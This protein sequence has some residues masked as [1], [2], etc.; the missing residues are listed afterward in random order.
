MKVVALIGNGVS[1]AYNKNLSIACLTKLLIN[2]FKETGDQTL[3]DFA[4]LAESSGAQDDPMSKGFEALLGPFD[5]LGM[6]LND[7][8]DFGTDFSEAN[9]LSEAIEDFRSKAQRIYR[10]GLSIALEAIDKLATQETISSR[11]SEVNRFYSE[12]VNANC[13]NN[14]NLTIAT[15]NYDTTIVSALIDDGRQKFCDLADPRKAGGFSD[16]PSSVKVY[17]LRREA[18]FPPGR[19]KLLQLHGSLNWLHDK[20][21]NR[22]IK[23]PIDELRGREVWK[24]WRDDEPDLRDWEPVVILTN[25]NRKEKLVSEY[26]FKLAYEA[27][28][29]TLEDADRLL[30]AGYGFGDKALN[31]IMANSLNQNDNCRIL[32]VDYFGDEDRRVEEEQAARKLATEALKLGAKSTDLLLTGLGVPKVVDDEIWLQWLSSD[33]GNDSDQTKS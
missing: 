29:N 8:S 21:K 14:E 31:E 24:K 6:I 17:Q 28:G 3:K 15:L 27:F 2:K 16:R 33:Q 10:N 9:A 32:V 25:Q 5:E 1:C 11:R 4:E 12:L 7:I 23:F 13:G 20:E 30:V 26:P 18:D 19:S 22:Y